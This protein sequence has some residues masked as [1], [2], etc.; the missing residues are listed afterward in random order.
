[1]NSN[2]LTDSSARA[3]RDPDHEWPYRW[4]SF[5]EI[6]GS[7][8]NSSATPNRATSHRPPTVPEVFARRYT[9]LASVL[10]AAGVIS[11]HAYHGAFTAPTVCILLGS[12]ACVALMTPHGPECSA[13]DAALAVVETAVAGWLLGIFCREIAAISPWIIVIPTLVP[14]PRP[15][16]SQRA[17]IALLGGF[18][19]VGLVDVALIW[20]SAVGPWGLR[21]ESAAAG[22]VAIMIAVSCRSERPDAELVNGVDQHP[23]VNW[24]KVFGIILSRVWIFVELATLLGLLWA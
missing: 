18:L 17:R 9:V 12:W 23:C 10:L 24:D 8:D 20:A 21:G 6:L 1:M 15:R 2:S 7:G 19:L 3:T 11:Y 13:A 16:V 4:P 14:L 22:V 5:E